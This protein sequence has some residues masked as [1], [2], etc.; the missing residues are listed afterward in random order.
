MLGFVTCDQAGIDRPDRGTDNP[1]RLDADF[2]QCLINAGLIGAERPTAL[3]HQHD[4]ARQTPANALVAP[5]TSVVL[6]IHHIHCLLLPYSPRISTVRQRPAIVTSVA[7]FVALERSLFREK[8]VIVHP[9]FAH[10]YEVPV[11]AT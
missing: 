3:E 9:S 5:G 1:V 2:V 8:A 11:R 10:P 7:A 6:H 4:L